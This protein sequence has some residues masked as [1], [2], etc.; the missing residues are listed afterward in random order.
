MLQEVRTLND[1]IYLKSK[2]LERVENEVKHLLESKTQAIKKLT[3]F[4]RCVQV[5][6][7]KLVHEEKSVIACKEEISLLQKQLDLAKKL[8]EVKKEYYLKTVVVENR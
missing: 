6:T 2:E 8:A 4:E 3:E 5:L 7:H 1:L